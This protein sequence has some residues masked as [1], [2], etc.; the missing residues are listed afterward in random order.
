MIL[1][2]IQSLKNGTTIPKPKATADFKIKGWGIRRGEPALTYWVPNHKSPGKPLVKGITVT[3]FTRAY[4]QLR[5][6]SSFTRTWFNINLDT[7]AKEG[8]CNFTTLGGIFQLLGVAHYARP[9]TYVLSSEQS[10]AGSDEHDLDAM[11][12]Q[13]LAEVQQEQDTAT[14]VN[15]TVDRVTGLLEEERKARFNAA[16][17]GLGILFGPEEA[18]QRVPK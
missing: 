10:A 18:D 5:E 3:E 16:I 15:S 4:D 8:S 1:D 11:F 6:N 2:K 14:K 17:D 9:G 12:D 13:I 7:C